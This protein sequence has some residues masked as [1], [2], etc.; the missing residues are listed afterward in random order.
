MSDHNCFKDK[1]LEFETI[2]DNRTFERMDP[3][4]NM[5]LLSRSHLV[6]LILTRGM[7][8]EKLLSPRLWSSLHAKSSEGLSFSCRIFLNFESSQFSEFSIDLQDSGL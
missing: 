6:A 5:I 8:L 4:R 7:G 3:L 1:R 2:L